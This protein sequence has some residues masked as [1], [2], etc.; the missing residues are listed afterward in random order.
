MFLIVLL[1]AVFAGTF[2][3][4]K[5]ILA[6]TQPIFVIGTRMTIAGALILIFHYWRTPDKFV[7][8]KDHWLIYLK[9]ML[10]TVFVPYLLRG[11]GLQYMPACKASFLYNCGPFISYLLSCLFYAEKVR[12][13]KIIGLIIGFLGLLPILLPMGMNFGE[14]S[15][16]LPDLAMILSVSSISYGWLMA[17]TLIRTYHYAPM[18]LN[19]IGMFGGGI[20]A[21]VASLCL[22]DS[23]R[24]VTQW[25]PFL[26]ILAAIII[27]SNLICHNLYATLLKTYTPTMLSFGGFLTP[28]FAGLYGWLFL[29]EVIDSSFFLAN[30]IVFV[31]LSLFYFEELQAVR[32]TQKIV[33]ATQP[34][35]NTISIEEK[36]IIIAQAVESD[37]Q[38][39]LAPG[40]VERNSERNRENHDKIH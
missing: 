5:V 34:S 4:G 15:S 1:Y 8:R 22:E 2:S 37:V 24:Y 21:L 9:M 12:T 27:V 7:L 26:M 10:F 30:A 36:E 32:A 20:M 18:F 17:H 31:G 13:K 3:L 16:F 39:T 28:F 33:P 38:P 11:W 23:S 19:G 14:S 6:Y 40:S 29:H 35:K 25:G